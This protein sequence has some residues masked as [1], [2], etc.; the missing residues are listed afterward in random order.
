MAKPPTDRVARVQQLWRAYE[1]EGIDAV[2]ALVDEDVVWEPLGANGQ[3][4]VGAKALR[5]WFV[6]L[7]QDGRR[8]SAQA[9]LYEQ[10]GSAVVVTGSLRQWES[11][12][13]AETQ[14][15]WLY[16]FSDDKLVR[17]TGFES[18]AD[19]RRAAGELED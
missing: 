12:G 4:I 14:P 15:G 6:S 7:E 13:F 2:V 19:A 8:Q 16:V 17:M 9:N 18:V 5:D 10:I 11:A 3:S 1:S